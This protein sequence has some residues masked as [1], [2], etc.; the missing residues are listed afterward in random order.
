MKR[1]LLLLSASTLI[2]AAL[3]EDPTDRVEGLYR[4]AG[5][6]TVAYDRLKWLCEVIGHRLSGSEELEQAIDWAVSE[7]ETD[8]MRV[9]T[10]DVL[11]PHWERNEE[12][13]TMLAPMDRDLHILGLGMTVGGEVEAEVVVVSSF[14]E[15]DSVDVT[16]KIVLY[17]VPFTTYGETVQYRGRGPSEASRRGAV[18]V[19]VRSVTPVS[20]Y[21][22]HTGATRYAED[23]PKIPAAAVTVED[24]VWMHGLQDQGIPIRVKLSLGAVHHPDSTSR[25]VIADVV[26]REKPDEAVVVGCHFDSWD[27]GQGAQDDGAGCLIAWEAARLISEMEQAPRRTVR[28]VLFT[29][30]E[31]GLRGGRAYAAEQDDMKVVAAFES[32]TG[33]GRADGFRVDLRAEDIVRAQAGVFEMT[34]ALQSIGGGT[35]LPGYAGADVG[36]LAAQGI[37]SFGMRHDTTTY[38]PIHHTRAD[39][40]EKV[41]L[42]D[43]QH[44][45]GLMAA[46]VWLLAEA[47]GTLLDEKRRRR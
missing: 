29:N 46:A 18:G 22:P 31:N 45:A 35:L 30:E 44:N 43:L 33:N 13:L 23:A 40:F 15:L 16:G 27:V 39:T 4:A 42:E 7:L 20:L 12:S 9:Q 47:E 41:V 17:D 38:W 34:A 36:P 2:A 24:A 26:G 8:G 10:Q 14:E 25:N 32:D 3:P 5:E 19:L 6:S 28:V 11:V 37:P 1:F 21:T